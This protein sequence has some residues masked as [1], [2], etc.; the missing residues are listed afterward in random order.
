MRGNGL[1]MDMGE[2]KSELRRLAFSRRRAAK[3][4]D[5]GAAE[6]AASRF[7]AAGF[8]NG[9][10]IVAGYRPIR[11]ELD[12]TPLMERLSARGLRLAVPVIEG[13]GLPLMFREWSPGARMT[14]GAFGA[15]VPA[16]GAWVEPDLLIV[17]LVAFDRALWRLGYGGGFYDRTLEGLRAQRP[18]QAIGYAFAAQAFDEVPREPTDQRL[19]AVVTE[20]EVI[21]PSAE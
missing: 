7:E 11:T 20:A 21:G 15:E 4:A 13:A 9:A 19:D 17:P 3:A 16:E 10:M 5:A 8:A 14:T 2:Y 1:A 6:A 12:P 18:T